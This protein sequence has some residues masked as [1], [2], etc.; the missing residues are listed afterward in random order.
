M[1]AADLPSSNAK[2]RVVVPCYN[3]EATVAKVVREFAAQPGV[4]EVIVVDNGSTDETAARG[5][6]AGARV[7][8]ETRPGKGFALITGLR[9]AGPADF[10]V[11]VDGD[12]TY[13][14]AYLPQLLASAERGADMVIATRLESADLGAFR[15]GHGFGN[16]LFIAMVGLLF[17]AK[18]NDLFSGYRVLSRRFL[19][20]VPLVAT[21]FEIELELHLQAVQH[22]FRI[23]EIPVPYRPR[24]A[25][26]ESK[27]RTFRD[28]SRILAALILL[29][30]DLRPLTFFGLLSIGLLGLSLA[31]GSVVVSGYLR[32][33]LVD[34]LPLAVLSA[35]L[36]TL[37]ALSLTC[38]VLLSSINRRA[39]EILALLRRGGHTT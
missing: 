32:T 23:A 7:V 4:A 8:T 1:P 10:Y 12:D 5:R 27:L 29:F 16:R 38:G 17:R 25:G 13:D 36:F 33:G 14:V 15:S 11:M 3:E 37:S 19:D 28:G 6:A 31:G 26:S 20:I 22:G 34:R 30:R 18:T 21:G 39:S 24:P 35:A 9:E 2:A